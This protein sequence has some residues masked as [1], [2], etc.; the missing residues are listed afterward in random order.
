ENGT[1][2]HTRA[3]GDDVVAGI[4]PGFQT[5]TRHRAVEAVLRVLGAG[6]QQF[7]GGPLRQPRGNQ[8]G[9]LAVVTRA[10]A[11]TKTTTGLHAMDG[12]K[13]RRKTQRTG[14]LGTERVGG[15]RGSPDFR[16]FSIDPHRSADR[17]HRRVAEEGCVVVR[18]DDAG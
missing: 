4:E 16:A 15:L 7:D 8:G 10:S 2:G 11:S 6:P 9:L 14:N 5:I 13:L 1:A 3:P 12:D 17:L 18:A